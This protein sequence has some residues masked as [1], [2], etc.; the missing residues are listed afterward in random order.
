[1]S[2]QYAAFLR[3]INLG[4]RRRVGGAELRE[5]FA[6]LGF[7]DVATFRTSGNVVFAAAR[8]RE[9]ELRRRIEE[10]VETALGY[11]VAVFLRSAKELRGLADER[12]FT[13]P[14]LKRSKGKQQVML[15]SKKPSARA[16]AKVL[17]LATDRD[18]LVFGERE[19]HWLPSGGTR[20]SGLDLPAIEELIGPTTM[21]TKGTIEQLA[22][23]Y[24]TA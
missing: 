23:K 1:M 24:L 6:D 14:Q 15:L 2:S 22:A 20:D 17:G 8:K 13:P 9:S 21:R 19:L 7:D 4:R 16:R 11:E 18:A 10:A 3:G 5:L 12:P